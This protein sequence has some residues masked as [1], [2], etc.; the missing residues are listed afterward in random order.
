MKYIMWVFYTIVYSC[1]T[2][3]ACCYGLKVFFQ[4]INPCLEHDT[5]WQRTATSYIFNSVCGIKVPFLFQ[6]LGSV[7]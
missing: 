6:L 2:I 7:G 4:N 5:G 1:N 3:F